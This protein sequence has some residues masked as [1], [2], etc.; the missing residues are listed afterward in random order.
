MSLLNEVDKPGSDVAQYVKDLDKMLVDKVYMILNMR[1]QLMQFHKNLKTEEHMSKL[2]EQT[3]E[4]EQEF[5]NYGNEYD[6]EMLIDNNQEGGQ[7]FQG[8]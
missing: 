6:D 4:M 2:Y 8:Y 3:R 5:N 7:E 1:K